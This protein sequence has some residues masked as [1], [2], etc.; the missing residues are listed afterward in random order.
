MKEIQ[1][2]IFLMIICI[3]INAQTYQGVFDGKKDSKRLINYGDNILTVNYANIW[4]NGEGKSPTGKG[5]DRSWYGMKHGPYGNLHLL[6]Y[7]PNQ[8]TLLV[9]TRLHGPWKTGSYKWEWLDNESL[10][11]INYGIYDWDVYN[12]DHVY[13]CIYESDPKD[14]KGIPIG[15]FRKHD[16]LITMRVDKDES[17]C[18]MN[19][20]NHN[21]PSIKLQTVDL[22]RTNRTWSTQKKLR[23]RN[24]SGKTIK[25]YVKAYTIFSN[26]N[27]GWTDW[28]GPFTFKSYDKSYYTLTDNSDNWTVRGTHIYI[29]AE[30]EDE[31]T[32]WNRDRYDY[33]SIQDNCSRPTS[34]LKKYSYSFD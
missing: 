13:I 32:N 31:K 11:Y 18:E 17:Y 25:V 28:I 19:Y 16:V 12:Y 7:A 21:V 33:I 30:S 10:D 5:S 23:V 2:L 29:Y 4:D 27:W 24:T 3:S 22:N 14:V 15:L 8:E 26:D 6:I 1:S 20:Y 34:E 9:H